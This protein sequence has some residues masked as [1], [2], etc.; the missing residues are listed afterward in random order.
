MYKYGDLKAH[1]NTSSSA[2]QF[3]KAV[4]LHQ[5][6]PYLPQFSLVWC[7]YGPSFRKQIMVSTNS[8]QATNNYVSNQNNEMYTMEQLTTFLT[9]KPGHFYS[10]QAGGM[11]NSYILVKTDQQE[12][13]EDVCWNTNRMLHMIR[14]IVTTEMKEELALGVAQHVNQTSVV[15]MNSDEKR[16]L[17]ESIPIPDIHWVW[18]RKP[19]Y[20]LTQEI[21]ERASSWI[22]LN[23]GSKFHLWTDIPTEADVED[24]LKNIHPE[25]KAQFRAATTIHLLHE[26]NHIIESM[27]EILDNDETAEGIRLL[28]AEFA[29]SER[30]SRVYKTDFFRLFV[31]WYC[32]GVYTDFNDLLCLAPIREALAIY[33]CESPVGV[34]DL[35]DL[36]HASNYFMYCPARN[37]HWLDILKGMVSHFVY[38]IRM[39]RDE[40]MEACVKQ[41]VLKALESC[42]SPTHISQ[43]ISELKAVYSRH[44]LPH[45][46]N[47]HISDSLWERILFVILVDCVPEPY[48]GIINTRLDMLKRTRRGKTTP[49]FQTL[50]A[51]E[52]GELRDII[53]TKFHVSFHFWW[54]DYNLRV[55]MHYTNLPIYC[56]MRKIPL[57]LL[58]FGY[59]VNYSCMLSYVGHIGDGTSYGMDGRKDYYVGNVYK[60]IP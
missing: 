6:I 21:I 17:I 2:Y 49:V 28:R 54:V 45:I 36:N 22:V 32:G 56:R 58:P 44:E 52:I 25:W 18:F 11:S 47:E 40:S 53:E 60:N 20:H 41:G 57:A 23:P 9:T 46:G 51:E 8:T 34:T 31:L 55:L 39:I 30:Q 1:L 59:F 27:L 3:G 38:L 4:Y 50:K 43:P 35:Y 5:S 16:T 26:T 37:T 19:G 24:F 10:I 12:S 14:W 42:T 7:A 13:L 29:S 33:G 48:K 15:W